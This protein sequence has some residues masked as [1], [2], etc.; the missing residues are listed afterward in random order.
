MRPTDNG[1]S[2]LT[3]LADL[4]FSFPFDLKVPQEV[5]IDEEMPETVREQ[6]AGVLVS[7]FGHKEGAGPERFLEDVLLLRL[8]FGVV[9][10]LSEQH[11]A[12]FK[13]RFPDEF[14]GVDDDLVLFS[15]ELGDEAWEGLL[16]R[17]AGLSRLL[18]K[19]K[20]PLQYV[21]DENTW[22]TLYADGLEFQTAYNV[23]EEQVRNRLRKPETVVEF[24]Q[25]RLV[26]PKNPKNPQNS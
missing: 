23:N 10:S 18:H 14:A 12:N 15:S 13:A 11:V 26:R 2:F 24:L 4:L 22:D 25:K 6:A 21:R 20:R 1:H 5:V 17:S 3:R 7:A 8:L 9:S 19:G 16:A